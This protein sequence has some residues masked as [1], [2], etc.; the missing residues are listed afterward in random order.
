MKIRVG[1]AL[2]Q[3]ALLPLIFAAC[4]DS[5]GLGPNLSWSIVPSGTVK[6]LDGVWGTSAS[7]V[8]A[9]GEETILHYDGAT[10]SPAAG[11]S[12]SALLGIWLFGIWGSS[13]SDI[14]A[15]GAAAAGTPAILHYDG[16]SWSSVPSPSTTESQYT[17]VSGSSASDVWVAGAGG[18]VSHYDGTDWSIVP[19]GT[20]QPLT[21]VWAS[22]PSDVWVVGFEGMFHYNGTSWAPVTG[23]SG[24]FLGLFGTSQSDVWAVG[25]APGGP[26]HYDGTNWSDGPRGSAFPDYALGVWASSRTDAWAVGVDTASASFVSKIA[27]YNGTTWSGVAMG[28]SS[29]IL[30]GAWGSSATDVW[31]VGD[32]G[33]ILHGMR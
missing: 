33:T 18:L 11:A 16:A 9:V 10:W 4:N 15:V 24:E 17:S 27:H 32:G 13:A 30:V 6:E 7:N 21:S 28:K 8:W 12:G 22:S 25:Q 3:V 19:T 31:V 23:M 14:W 26:S 2:I 5:T 20:R 1:R 29:A